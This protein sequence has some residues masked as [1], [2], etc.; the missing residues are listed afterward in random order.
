[1]KKNKPVIR[2]LA[3]ILFMFGFILLIPAILAYLMQ[4]QTMWMTFGIEAVLCIAIATATRSKTSTAGMKQYQGAIA[5]AL[6]WILISI[7]SSIPYQ[8]NGLGLIDSLFE[9]F[10]GWTNTGASMIAEPEQLPYSLG[11]FRAMSQWL[12]GLGLVLILISLRGPSPRIM[13]RLFQAEGRQEDFNTS[14]WKMGRTIVIIYFSY[15]L[16]GF[17]GMWAAGV[18]PFHAITHTMT[19]LSTGGFSS[20]SIG[21]GIYGALPTV[22][23]ILLMIAGGVS[24][25][26][27]QAL[28]SGNIKKF[29][30][31][32]EV[33]IFAIILVVSSGLGLLQMQIANLP[34]M[35]NAL[36]TIFYVVSAASTTGAHTILPLQEV[37]GVFLFTLTIL[38]ATGAS[39]GSATGGLKLWRLIILGKIISRE[40]RAPF[41]PS[42]TILPIRMGHNVI[43]EDAV[44]KVAGYTMLYT[45]IALAGSLIFMMFGYS[46]LDSLFVVFSA[47]GNVGLTA[48]P[49]AVHLGMQPVLKLL[50]VFHM[51]IGRLEIFPLL[52]IVVRI[53]NW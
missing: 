15:T 18:P 28:F 52:Y 42:G 12:S 32:P 7:I 6:A 26:S 13:Q 49:A 53:R 9:S 19:S 47:Q 21:I 16:A 35:E 17:L 39:Y 40:M 36:D 25:S 20:N 30:Q 4:E 5:L 51:L 43:Q 45:S 8:V 1:M 38:M 44:G 48:M 24:F 46:V 11:L 31:N 33:R 50:L 10:S 37:P 34:I 29:V 27:H 3:D 2:L 41:Y 22:I 14:A 23:A